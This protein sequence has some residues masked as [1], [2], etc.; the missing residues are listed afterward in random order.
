MVCRGDLPRSP[1]TGQ[2]T[3]PTIFFVRLG[4]VSSRLYKYGR[5]RREASSKEGGMLYSSHW[6]AHIDVGGGMQAVKNGACSFLPLTPF[7]SPSPASGTQAVKRG[8]CSFPA[9]GSP[10]LTLAEGASP[11]HTRGVAGFPTA[12][13]PNNALFASYR[14]IRASG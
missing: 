14:T 1:G 12:S 7:N 9:A 6:L 13:D 2:A 8:A 3:F 10:I 5:L 4:L 11:L